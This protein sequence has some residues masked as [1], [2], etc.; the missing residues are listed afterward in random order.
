MDLPVASADDTVFTIL[1][2]VTGE[3]ARQEITNA[4]HYSRAQKKM[5]SIGCLVRLR[6][7]ETDPF[8]EMAKSE[9]D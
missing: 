3:Y 4:R 9:G 6:L 2:G 7:V 5:P 8:I 1:A